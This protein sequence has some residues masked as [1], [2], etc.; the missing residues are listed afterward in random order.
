MT[1]NSTHCKLL[2]SYEMFN[3][4]DASHISVV[5]SNIYY[6]TSNNP[7][8]HFNYNDIMAREDEY[9]DFSGIYHSSLGNISEP[10]SHVVELMSQWV[11]CLGKSLVYIYEFGGVIKAW[12]FSKS[13]MLSIVHHEL[14]AKTSNDIN[15][16]LWIE[17]EDSYFNPVDFLTEGEFLYDEDVGALDSIDDRLAIIELAQEEMKESFKT[18]TEII[19][20]QNRKK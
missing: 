9:K 13:T 10:S 15:Y 6:G 8:V 4:A 18:L 14:R 2:V 12:M 19:K 1:S 11:K 16:D 17:R 7:D 3:S 5:S 20:K